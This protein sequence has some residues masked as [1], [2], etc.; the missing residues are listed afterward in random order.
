[1]FTFTKQVDDTYRY[2]AQDGDLTA[3]LVRVYKGIYS[4]NSVWA[5]EVRVCDGVV[6]AGE[7]YGRTPFE[8]A[9]TKARLVLD[10]IAPAFDL[11]GRE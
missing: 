2:S 5:W 7:T 3:T 10:C 1:M 9:K 6:D 8:D 11:G 4:G